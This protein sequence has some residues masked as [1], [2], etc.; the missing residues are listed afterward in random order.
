[1]YGVTVATMIWWYEFHP[2]QLAER[3]IQGTWRAV[4]GVIPDERSGDSFLHVKDN[5]TWLVYPLGD[6]WEVQRSRITVRPADNFFVVRR[7]FGFDYGNTRETEYIVHI[8][9]DEMYI[10]RGLSRLDSVRVN[11]IDKLRS[12]D[13]LPD[14]ASISIQEYLQRVTNESSNK[15]STS[16]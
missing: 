5:E 12:G 4:E 13:S 15:H 8:K 11:T 16:R 9:K 3:E 7:E 1:M 10:L 2:V 14:G 6:K